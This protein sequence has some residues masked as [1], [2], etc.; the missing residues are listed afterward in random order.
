MLEGI[1]K[2]KALKIA[3]LFSPCLTLIENFAS[4]RHSTRRME[5][6]SY[7]EIVKVQISVNFLL[8]WLMNP[9]NSDFVLK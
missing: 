4:A 2:Q 3:L 7:R 6:V 5:N 1:F 8:Q 9:L